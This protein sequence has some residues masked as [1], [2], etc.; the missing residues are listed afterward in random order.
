MKRRNIVRVLVT[1]LILSAVIFLISC[2][3]PD[4]S[5]SHQKEDKKI[6]YMMFMFS[7]K[8]YDEI[9]DY[10]PEMKRLYG[11]IEPSS[12]RMYAFGLPGPMLLTQSAV[13]MQKEINTGFDYAEKYNIPVY[14]QLDDVTNYTTYYGDG[15]AVKFYEH[16][17]MCEWISFPKKGETWGGEGDYGKLPRFWFNWGVWM[18]SPAFPN[19]ASPEFKALI[20]D[21]MQKGVL[22]PLVERYNRLKRR[23]KGYLFAGVA[24]GWETHIPDY[25][26]DNMILDTDP[27]NPPSDI[28]TGDTME[29]WEYG[30]YGYAALHTLGYNQQKLDNEAKQKNR[31]PNSYMKTLLYGVIHDFSEF[32]AKQAYDAG[33]PRNK[34]FTHMVSFSTTLV[35][36]TTFAP[37]TWCAVN[38]YSTPG[39]TMNP[40]TCPYDI[41]TLK[42]EIEKADPSMG[43]FGCVEGYATGL[44]DED[45]ASDYLKEMFSNGA[46]IVAVFSYA[47]EGTRQFRFE[48][49][50]DFGFNIAVNK[51]LRGN[52]E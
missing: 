25:S 20:A 21:N 2:S 28:I 38:K 48:R 22:A 5:G 44:E 11:S 1:A 40:V 10:L 41:D 47:D 17:G 34:L 14:F 33:I 29:K 35:T 12:D 37:P 16:P 4:E 52:L 51:W 31:S 24:I 30:Q 7:N 23:G 32:M 39:F 49:T 9:E 27:S 42:A 8:R 18:Q 45:K 26:R 6:Q 13:E 36:N 43:N 3:R 50:P 15:A 46:L 19:L